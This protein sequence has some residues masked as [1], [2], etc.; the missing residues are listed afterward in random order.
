[1]IRPPFFKCLTHRT[2]R[3]KHVDPLADPRIIYTIVMLKSVCT[4]IRRT[5]PDRAPHGS[6]A[7]MMQSIYAP[8]HSAPA[9]QQSSC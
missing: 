7:M 5:G 2:G 6:L 3:T 4:D 9:H 8:P 1:M